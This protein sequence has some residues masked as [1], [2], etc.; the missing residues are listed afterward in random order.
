M[1]NPLRNVGWELVIEFLEHCGCYEGATQGDDVIYYHPSNTQW[2]IKV[3]KAPKY[4]RSGY[5]LGTLQGNLLNLRQ[6]LGID[7]KTCVD[8]FRKKRNF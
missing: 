2:G 1:P 5:P 7:K 3:N 6:I 8:W 4:R